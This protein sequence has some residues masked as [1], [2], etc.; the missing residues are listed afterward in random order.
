MSKSK[1]EKP[2]ASACGKIGHVSRCAIEAMQNAYRDPRVIRVR[3]LCGSDGSRRMLAPCERRK[4]TRREA[5]ELF[6]LLAAMGGF[7]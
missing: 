1:N 2:S 7:Q 4:M 3:W 6:A 5:A